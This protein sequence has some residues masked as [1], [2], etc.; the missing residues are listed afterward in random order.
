MVPMVALTT[1]PSAEED[2]TP[3]TGSRGKTPQTVTLRR[4]PSP[5]A[6]ETVTLQGPSAPPG[7]EPSPCAQHLS[8]CRGEASPCAERA[9]P[10]AA[11]RRL[12]AA[13]G[14]GG[15]AGIVTLADGMIRSPHLVRRIGTLMHRAPCR[16]MVLRGTRPFQ[17][18]RLR[19]LERVSAP[20]FR[21]GP[22][23]GTSGGTAAAPWRSA[24]RS[25]PAARP[26]RPRR[27]T[28]IRTPGTAGR[29][30]RR[31]RRWRRRRC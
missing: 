21:A 12:A 6:P 28:G 25:A 2:G 14:L 13:P 24:R 20:A 4:K 5:C 3:G 23:A 8:P 10:C 7:R 31:P 29:R 9:S 11:K 30:W 22:G 1:R 19:L 26:P 18:Y 16:K 17:R 27:P 15:R